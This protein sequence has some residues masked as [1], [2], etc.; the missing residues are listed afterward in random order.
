[1]KK[2]RQL[3][4][5]SLLISLFFF[6]GCEEI[7][8]TDPNTDPRDDFVGQWNCNE[9]PAK[10]KNNYRVNIEYDSDN[11]SQ[12]LLFN[13]GLL[14]NTAAAY[15]IVAG[16]NVNIPLQDVSGGW[17]AQGQGELVNDN[18]IEWTYTLD[19]GSDRIDYIAT[20]TLLD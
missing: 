18:Q 12:V 14:G 3:I 1:M 7:D 15:G 9:T 2:T 20:Y 17:S 10:K 16:D 19:N 11:S 4:T 6:T 5:Y 13:F 8:N